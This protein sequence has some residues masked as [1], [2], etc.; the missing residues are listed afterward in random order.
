M[1]KKKILET[2]LICK[3]KCTLNANFFHFVNYSG[4]RYCSFVFILIYTGLDNFLLLLLKSVIF[5][6]NFQILSFGF[7][8]TIIDCCHNGGFYLHMNSLVY[9]V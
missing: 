6:N 7:F 3:A 2:F 4:K 9:I 1:A 5:Q 8:F